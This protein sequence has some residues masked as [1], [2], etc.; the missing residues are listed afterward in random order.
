M[1][2][3]ILSEGV[4]IER[5]NVAGIKIAGLYLKLNKKLALNIERLELS[6]DSASDSE[7]EISDIANMIKRA[8]LVSSFFE[9]LTIENIVYGESGGESKSESSTESAA[10]EPLSVHFDGESYR[11]NLPY[12]AALFRLTNDKNDIFLDIDL[13]RVKNE[14]LDLKGRVLY[15]KKGNIFA[16]DIDSYINNR[17]DNVLSLRGETDFKR[18]FVV[19]DSSVLHAIDI[20]EPYIKILDTDIHEWIFKRTTFKTLQ[21]KTAHLALKNIRAKNIEKDIVQNLYALGEAEGVA[22]RF[23]DSLPQVIAP[24]VSVRF[25]DSRI[26][27]A[28]KDANYDGFSA[29]AAAQIS[30]FFATQTRL[31][32]HIALKNAMLD[33]RALALL[34]AYDI[35][36]PFAQKDGT[37]EGQIEISFLL[38]TG[39]LGVKVTP[40]GTF[41]AQNSTIDLSGA[42]IF[43]K[44]ADITLDGDTIE[45]TGAARFGE[46]LDSPLRL[47]IDTAKKLMDIEAKPTLLR[48]GEA[49][50]AIFDFGGVNLFATADFSGENFSIALKNYDINAIFSD[51][52]HITVADFGKVLAHSPLLRLLGIKHGSLRVETADFTDIALFA[53]LSALAYPLYNLNGTQITEIALNGRFKDEKL[54]IEDASKRLDATISL[55]DSHIAL[56]AKNALIDIDEVLSSNI[57]LFAKM[58]EDTPNAAAKNQTR[59]LISAKNVVLKLFAHQIALDEGMLNTTA[60]GFIANGSNKNGIANLILNNGIIRID[61]NNFND[62]F[63]NKLVGKEVVKSGTFGLYGVYR[64]KRFLGDVSI[65]NTSVTNLASLQNIITLIDAIPSLVVFKLPGFSTSGYE[66]EDASIRV[67]VD[68]EFAALE[69]IS[70]NGSSV[71]IEGSGVIDLKSSEMDMDLDL[72][73]LKSLSS[74]L[75]KI[76]VIGYILL[77]DDGKITTTLKVTGKLDNPKTEI[78]ILKDATRAPVDIVKRVF[79]PF[80]ILLDELKKGKGK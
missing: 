73:T 39:N 61:A 8:I 50:N 30:D 29:E 38:P 79:T 64:G 6:A 54:T 58:R 20:L 59:I 70:V 34:N 13:L 57:P 2:F 41:H 17:A 1:V 21:L 18:L 47:K 31:D 4:K 26:A 56:G 35:A 76:P 53:K 27:F 32:L 33:S 72:S 16:F 9:K 28:A 11:I 62:E 10:A 46:M 44:R 49:E 55:K 15:H 63:I 67:G 71:D 36:L 48:L 22:L 23:E 12:I 80:Q 69:K 14:N 43:A 25:A 60:G 24:K 7:P 19:A 74:I 45:V 78:S 52:I 42:E 75:N 40:K 3:K 5:L 68:S 37:A 66:I 51:K 65:K 77:G